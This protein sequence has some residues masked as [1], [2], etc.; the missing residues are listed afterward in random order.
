MTKYFLA[1][2]LLVA[3]S[4]PNASAVFLSLEFG[5]TFDSMSSLGGTA[6]GVD[7]PFS[8]SAPFDSTA[9]LDG[10]PGSGFFETVLTF[11]INGAIFTSDPASDIKVVLG[12]GSAFSVGLVDDVSPSGF[13]VG[14][15][16]TTLPFNADAPSPTIFTNPMGL[17]PF[18]PLTVP[19]AD[20]AGD[21]VIEG[22]VTIGSSTA[23]IVTPEPTSILV[24]GL[25]GAVGL[26]F[27]RRKAQQ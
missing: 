16:T 9:D 5:G 24:W 14:F 17:T 20:G 19:L 7:T 23:Q 11:E 26:Q 6:F 2:A 25:L 10:N 21:L 12:S 15:S 18:F 13:F 1:C 4:A 22:L 8:F 27:C 3:C